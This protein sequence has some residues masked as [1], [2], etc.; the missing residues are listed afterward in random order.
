M[1]V[2]LPNPVGQLSEHAIALLSRHRGRTAA[3]VA[4]DDPLDHDLQLALYVLNELHYA[5]WYGIDDDL[6][7]DPDVT[8]TRTE[9]GS[10]FERRLRIRF[11]EIGQEPLKEARRLLDLDGPS[12]SAHL[13]DQG[14][15]DQLIETMMLRS[16][17]QVKEADPHTFALPRF[18]GPVKRVFTEIQSGEYGVGYRRSHA[19]LFSDA[20]VALDLDPTPNA[21]INS[22]NGAALATSNLVTLG[23]MNRRLRGLVLGQL[24]LFEMDSVIPNQAMVECCDRLGLDPA[25]RAFFS[26]HVLADAEHQV[27]AETAFL[28][29]Y[30][31][32]E[33]D[34]V[35]NL[36]LGLRGQSLID[37][38][39]AADLIPRWQHAVA[40]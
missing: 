16:P 36:I 23:A 34:Q 13:R 14:S 38:Q 32:A 3:P 6:E 19:E 24:A 27:M 37:H 25:V 35:A 2:S 10:E 22:C 39:I 33:P 21:H 29:D 17:Y 4:G 30:P 40:A 11:P 28:T 31:E 18:T 20:L 9:L 8:A 1:T 7:W 5:S 15:V 12:V 26:V